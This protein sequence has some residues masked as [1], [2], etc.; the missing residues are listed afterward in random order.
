[1]AVGYLSAGGAWRGTAGRRG[2]WGGREMGSMGRLG[3]GMRGI[4]EALS[5]EAW[6]MAVC[7]LFEA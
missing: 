5:S 1:M 2:G 6:H 3:R 4:T 7:S